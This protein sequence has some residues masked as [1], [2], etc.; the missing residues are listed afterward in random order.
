M[1]TLPSPG[2]TSGSP[3]ALSA[4]LVDLAIAADDMNDRKDLQSDNGEMI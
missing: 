4:N 2:E 1:A 3:A